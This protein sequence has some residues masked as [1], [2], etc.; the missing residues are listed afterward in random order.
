MKIGLEVLKIK[1]GLFDLN[2]SMKMVKTFVFTNAKLS[3]CINLFS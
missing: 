1:R 3:H 2:S